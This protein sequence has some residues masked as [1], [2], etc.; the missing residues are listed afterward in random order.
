[1]F[2][3]DSFVLGTSAP[4]AAPS[5]RLARCWLSLCSVFGMVTMKVKTVSTGLGVNYPRV[6]GRFRALGGS[7]R[8][9]FTHLASWPPPARRPGDVFTC[10]ISFC[11]HDVARRGSWGSLRPQ[12]GASPSPPRPAARRRVPTTIQRGDRSAHSRRVRRSGCA[13]LGGHY[14]NRLE[15]GDALEGLH[16]RLEA[17]G[18]VQ[19]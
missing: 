3:F 10:F 2:G 15:E 17:L 13:H 11:R 9:L 6:A 18:R 4:R 16:A 5:G 8:S 14:A 19:G 1:M 7:S 12:R